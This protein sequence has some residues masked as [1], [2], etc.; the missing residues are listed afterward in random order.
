M[1]KFW[2][3]ILRCGDKSYYV[4]V[5]DDLEKRIAI[6]KEGLD[7]NSYTYQRRPVELVY[8]EEYSSIN[9]AI[10]REKQLQ[11]WSRKKKEALIRGDLEKL[12][13]L[14]MKKRKDS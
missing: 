4:G 3:Y 13:I 10:S 5:T 14:A 11:G 8:S 7:K 2:V 12:H 6:H 1:R 9:D